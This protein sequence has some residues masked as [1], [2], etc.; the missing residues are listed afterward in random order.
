MAAI[1]P[2]S[3]LTSEEALLKDG[4]VFEKD[5]ETGRQIE[6]MEANCVP[7]ASKAG[8]QFYKANVLDDP[9]FP[10]R[11]IF[12]DQKAD[13]VKAQE[14]GLGLLLPVVWTGALSNVWCHPRRLCLST[15]QFILKDGV[16]PDTMLEEG[17]DGYILERFTHSAGH[18]HE[19]RK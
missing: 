1:H 19:G 9:V 15:E 14:T 6:E 10:I 16:S 5:A 7:F 11:P 4:F 2:T 13:F 3:N 8:L 18:Y 12:L 17:F